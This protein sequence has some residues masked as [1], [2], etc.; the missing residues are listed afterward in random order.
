MGGTLGIV[1]HI[2]HKEDNT[3]H[4]PFKFIICSKKPLKSISFRNHKQFWNFSVH[5]SHL[6]SRF[7]NNHSSCRFRWSLVTW[8][9]WPGRYVK[10]W[11]SIAGS[12]SFPLSPIASPLPI[13]LEPLRRLREA[14]YH[15]PGNIKQTWSTNVAEEPRAGKKCTLL[16]TQTMR[17]VM[18]YRSFIYQWNQF[19]LKS[20]K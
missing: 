20:A 8:Y 15:N 9:I 14:K 13:P 7:V 18:I 5:R 4:N 19:L 11:G 12:P 2:C 17:F 16:K 10:T 3:L 1:F 6:C